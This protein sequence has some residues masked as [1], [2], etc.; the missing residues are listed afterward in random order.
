MS[1]LLFAGGAARAR[2]RRAVGAERLRGL[3]AVA[4][5][6]RRAAGQPHPGRRLAGAGHPELRHAGADQALR[7]S[8][9]IAE[10]AC[11]RYSVS[12]GLPRL[13]EAI[14]EALQRDGMRYDPDARDPG[15]RRLD[16]GHRRDAAG[17]HRRRA[18]R[19]WWCRRPTPRTCRRSG[20]PAAC[21]AS[22]RST[23]TPTSTSIPTPSPRP[24]AGAR[25]RC[26]SA[27][28]TTR[29]A[30]SSR[31]S[32]RCACCDV[33]ERARPA[34]HHR[35]GLQGLRLRRRSASS[36]PRWSRRRASASSASAR[37]RRPTA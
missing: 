24:P 5:Q 4:D 12:P 6:G 27:T 7:R 14:A 30:R 1:R 25:A 20:S 33:A 17:Q 18:T 16:R 35:R 8:R 10:G 2:E 36:A 28:R 11:A 21:R 23:R 19:C 34:G 37:S 22:C 13:R 31:A 32:R 9:R 26:C 3:D 29:P 15:H